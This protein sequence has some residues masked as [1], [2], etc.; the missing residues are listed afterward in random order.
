MAQKVIQENLQQLT[1]E[2]PHGLSTKAGIKMALNFNKNKREC[3]KTY[4]IL[5]KNYF[6]PGTQPDELS[7]KS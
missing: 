6:Q 3:S 2:L 1:D 7:V 4:K 5:R